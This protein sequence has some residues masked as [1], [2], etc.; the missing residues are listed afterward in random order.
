MERNGG[1][2]MNKYYNRRDLKEA[3][4]EEIE[5]AFIQLQLFEKEDDPPRPN[6]RAEYSSTCI[7][8][9]DVYACFNCIECEN[10]QQISFCRNQEGAK[11]KILNIQ[12]TKKEYEN[13]LKKWKKNEGE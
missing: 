9:S 5:E 10:S 11:Y 12:F 2:E 3:T 1:D 13:I 7:S 6:I 4:Y 8:C